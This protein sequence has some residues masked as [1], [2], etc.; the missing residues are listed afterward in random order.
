MLK[1]MSFSLHHINIE[2]G[3]TFPLCSLSN[4]AICIVASISNA[5]AACESGRVG[6]NMPFV[7]L[8]D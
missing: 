3:S 1:P 2:Q 5:P 7:Q 8:Q 4:E 6:I